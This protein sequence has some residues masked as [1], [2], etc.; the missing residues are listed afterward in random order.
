MSEPAPLILQGRRLLARGRRAEARR[1][2][3]E[4]AAHSPRNEEAWL[5][6]AAVSSPRASLA[7]L[8]RALEINPR[9]EVA[10]KGI[11]WARKRMPP[12]NAFAV[13]SLQ[14]PALPGR[15][16]PI[17]AGRP[18]GLWLMAS[19]VALIT[20]LVLIVGGSP[21]VRRAAAQIA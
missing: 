10:H 14:S 19:G 3:Q 12:S 11:A 15:G 18:L 2:F 8:A 17:H 21:A 20:T 6:L 5:M 13:S 7:Y 9:S 1:L 4:A 16:S